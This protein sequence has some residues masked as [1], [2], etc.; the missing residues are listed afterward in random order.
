MKLNKRKCHKFANPD[1]KFPPNHGL[2]HTSQISYIIRTRIKIIDHHKILILYVYLR[3]QVVKGNCQPCYTVFQSKDD[4]ITLARKEDGST[5]WRKSAFDNLDK[6]YWFS[7]SCAFYSAN[8]EKRVSR[9]FKADADSGFKP[10]IKAQ[11]AILARRRRERQLTKERDIIDRMSDIPALPRDLKSWIKSVMPSYF[12]YQKGGEN[13]SGVCSACGQEIIL[14][15]VKQW[16]KG[17]CPHCKHEFKMKPRS[18]RGSNMHDR[19]TF[20]VIQNTGNGELVIRIVKVYYNYHG[21]RPDIEVYENARQFIWQDADGEIHNEAYYY[22]YS[23]GILTNWKK[24]FRPVINGWQAHFEPNT[25]GHLYTKNFPDA[26]HGTPWQ[27]CPIDIFYNHFHEPMEVFSFLSAYLQHPRLEALVKNHF[28]SIASDLAYHYIKPDVIDETHNRTHRILQVAAEDVSFLQELDVNMATLK[29]FQGYN[30]LK[31]RQKLLLWQMEHNVERDI[32]PVLRYITAHKMI[33]YLDEQYSFLKLRRTP[34]GT[35]RYDSMQ[36]LTTEYRDYLEM[37]EKMEYDL[38]NSFV[39]YPKDLQKSH[40][41]VARRLKHKTDAKTK[42]D[43]IAVYKSI[44]GQYAFE[45]NGLKIVYPATT[46]SLVEESH[47]LRHCVQKYADRVAR[48]ECIILFLRQCSDE[49]K[50]YYTIEICD[51]KVVQVRGY[52]NCVATPEVQRFIDAFR[53]QVLSKLD[54]AA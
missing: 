32:L 10:F 25:C 38:K 7:N 33:R 20:A 23:D 13:I 19:K 24:G 2:L 4:Y 45:Q 6:S 54:L 3:K 30:G 47:S 5:T 12:F 17:I 18:R 42:R 53:Q 48:H 36:A 9:Y 21:D 26:L 15:H 50:P 51:H 14:P 37:C 16:H 11:D 49:T 41:S 28:C 34:H 1:L 8:D 29:I 35:L 22:S 27:Y 46:Q 44:A 31:D 43:F 39:L 52:A 40:D